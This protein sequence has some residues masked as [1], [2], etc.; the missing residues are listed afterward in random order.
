LYSCEIPMFYSLLVFVWSLFYS[1]L[2]IVW[3][4]FYYL[5]VFMWSLSFNPCLYSCKIAFA[6]HPMI[7]SHQP[8]GHCKPQPWLAQINCKFRCLISSCMSA[9][10]SRRSPA[11]LPKMA[12]LIAAATV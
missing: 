9:L 12:H 11:F 10:C 7:F 3:S 8:L 6:P 5:F 1:L 2:V 4:L